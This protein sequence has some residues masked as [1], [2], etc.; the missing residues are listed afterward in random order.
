MKKYSSQIVVATVCALLGFLLSYQFK[1]L[2]S[3]ERKLVNNPN[4]Q[5]D[6]T[7]EISQL[8]KE[9]EEYEKKNNELMNQIKVYEESATNENAVAKE[10]KNQL[11]NTRLLI[12]SVDVTGPGVI[13][14][15]NPKT[16]VFSSNMVASY[17]TD[18]ELTYLV[19]ELF[20]AGAEAVSINNKRITL[21][22]G[23]KS[24]SGGTQI[25]INDERISPKETI[26][27]K[28]IGNKSALM[29]GLNFHGVLDYESL[30]YY[31]KKLEESDDVEIPKYNKLY[32][33]EY[34]KPVQ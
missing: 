7:K 27:I 31:E 9:K 32:K 6:I 11:D 15:L 8:T 3:E 29:G 22:T 25:L 4:V 18:R 30:A 34:I 12:G 24:S 5:Q 21:Q 23:I 19:N 2:N 28:A 13:L 10:L 14:Y 1:L 17:I 16:N 33:Y 20:F 26:T